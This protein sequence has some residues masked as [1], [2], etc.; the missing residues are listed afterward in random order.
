MMREAWRV[1]TQEFRLAWRDRTVAVLGVVMTLMTATATV[2]AQ[3]RHDTEAAQRARYQDVVGRQFAD[4]PDRHPHRVSHYGYLVFRPRAPLGYFDQGVETF[5]GTSIFLEAHRQNSANFSAASQS[6]GAGRFGEFTPAS[7]LQLFLPLF[8][9][10]VAGVSVTRERENG[11]LP[12][13]L[14]QGLS[15]PRILCGKVGGCLLI[16]ASVVVPAA[17]LLIAWMAARGELT[18]SA[19]TLGRGLGLVAAHALFFV[20]CTALAVAVSASHTTSRGALVSLVAIWFALWIV[21]PR[22]VPLAATALYPVPARAAFD[23]EVDVRVRELGDSHNPDDPVFTRFRADTLKRYGVARVEDLPLNYGGLVMREGERH[24][25]EAFEDHRAHL[26]AIYRSQARLVDLT[27]SL[28]PYLAIRGISMALAG[29]N[30]E[31]LFEF[32]RQAEAF[33]YDLIQGLNEL[34]IHEVDAARDRY[35]DVTNGAPSR[36]RIDAGFFRQLPIF[37]YRRPSLAWALR[38]HGAGLAAAAVGVIL[39]LSG[40]IQRSRQR[41]RPT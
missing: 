34:H 3:A 4:Q 28:S 10:G 15:W 29:S 1:A 36:Q 9:F 31:H 41:P 22:L 37:D 32:E 8:L 5:A 33:R 14:C 11:T 27:G 40:L 12:L 30:A 23:A 20:A 7:A 17:L 24:S 39:I 18:S 35:G 16:A 26:L 6:G 13:L 38:T 2:V 19:D 21:V 25:A